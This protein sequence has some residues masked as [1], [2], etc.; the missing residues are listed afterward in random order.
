MPI[1]GGV[2]LFL[3]SHLVLSLSIVLTL[4]TLGLKTNLPTCGAKKIWW[5][6]FGLMILIYARYYFLRDL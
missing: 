3:Q 2:V 4:L 6:A 5:L 1:M